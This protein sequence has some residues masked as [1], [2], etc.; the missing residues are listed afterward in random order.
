MNVVKLLRSL[1]AVHAGNHHKPLFPRHLGK[2]RKVIPIAQKLGAILIR[3][4]AGIVRHRAGGIDDGSLNAVVAPVFAPHFQVAVARI[5]FHA[6]DLIPTMRPLIP[7]FLGSPY[8]CVHGVFVACSQ[9]YNNDFNVLDKL[10]RK[11]T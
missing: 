3:V 5:V 2:V 8:G 7:R 6:V 10:S 9:N 4:A 11:N 1:V